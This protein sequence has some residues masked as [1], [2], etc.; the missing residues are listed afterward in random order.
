MLFADACGD[1]RRETGRRRCR[2]Q[3][4]W[5]PTIGDEAAAIIGRAVDRE[6]DRAVDGRR[7]REMDK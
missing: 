6:S 4:R 1:A 2:L 3:R 7:E 5:T